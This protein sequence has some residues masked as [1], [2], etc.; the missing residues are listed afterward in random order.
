MNDEP[1][2]RSRTWIKP[3][4]FSAFFCV[5]LLA[6]YVPAPL[7]FRDI[8]SSVSPMDAFL[9]SPVAFACLAVESMD[10]LIGRCFLVTFLLLLFVA[11]AAFYNSKRASVAMPTIVL[12][13]SL[14]QGLITAAINGLNGLNGV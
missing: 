10:P 9:R 3:V 4:I 1:K 7:F 5:N 13:Y 6:A 11:S 12:V 2:R 8:L 14:L